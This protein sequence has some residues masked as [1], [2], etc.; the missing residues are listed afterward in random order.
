MRKAALLF[1]LVLLAV[2]SAMAKK[3]DKKAIVDPRVVSARY[4][5]VISATGGD[6]DP[7]TQSED[8]AAITRVEDALQTWGRYKLVF[9][10]ANA[11]ILLVVRSGRYVGAQVGGNFPGTS[12]RPPF[13]GDTQPGTGVSIGDPGSPGFGVGL[14]GS[15]VSEDMISIYEARPGMTGDDALANSPVLWRKSIP[16][17]LDGKVPLIEALRKDVTEAEAALQ[18]K[19]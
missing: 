19:P 16:R 15:N 13:P 2:V 9:N 11:D 10:T 12:P 6:L 7:R 5:R 18:K 8:R 1:A 3:K 4:V 14:E 17:G